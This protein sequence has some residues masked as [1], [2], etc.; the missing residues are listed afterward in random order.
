MKKTYATIREWNG[1]LKLAVVPENAK[2]Q[3]GEKATTK[4]GVLGIIDGIHILE[5][6]SEKLKLLKA[7]FNRG[8]MLHVRTDV[9]YAV[10]ETK[11]SLENFDDGEWKYNRSKKHS[12]KWDVPEPGTPISEAIVWF[13]HN[14]Q[15]FLDDKNQV[16]M[17]QL[18]IV[19]DDGKT[20]NDIATTRPIFILKDSKGVE[21]G[22]F[23]FLSDLEE[24]AAKK[25][26]TDYQIVV[27]TMYEE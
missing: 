22:R 20:E 5:D 7:A 6:D 26:L 4:E 16:H 14:C 19:S 25:K 15:A 3:E 18:L 2:I 21:H 9:K 12:K 8:M 11:I 17:F 13:G 1:S 27:E 10:N 24:K 23:L